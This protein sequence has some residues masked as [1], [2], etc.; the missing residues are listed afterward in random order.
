MG[1][2]SGGFE[3]ISRAHPGNRPI[4]GDKGKSGSGGRGFG[5]GMENLE[6]GPLE[7]EAPKSNLQRP[8]KKKFGNSKGNPPKTLM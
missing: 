4:G 1:K 8:P 5:G 3:N 6:S 7:E 2:N